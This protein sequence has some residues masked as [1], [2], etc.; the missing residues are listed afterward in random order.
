ML[1]VIFAAIDRRVAATLSL[2]PPRLDLHR[3]GRPGRVGPGRP[4]RPGRPQ[5]AAV[6]ARPPTLG[7]VIPRLLDIAQ[8]PAKLAE[9]IGGALVRDARLHR[10][11]GGVRPGVRRLAPDRRRRGGLPDRQRDRLGRCPTPGGIGAVEAALSAGLTAAGLHGA[12][13]FSAVLLFRTVTFW[14]P[15]PFGWA[16]AA[17][18]CSAARSCDLTLS[19]AWPPPA[20]PP[21]APRPRTMARRAPSSGASSAC[22]STRGHLPVGE[23]DAA[24]DPDRPAPEG[25]GRRA[26]PALRRRQGERRAR[27]EDRGQRRACRSAP[28]RRSAPGRRPRRRRSRGRCG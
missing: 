5:A 11:P 1:L 19:R 26:Q 21:A 17:T 16:R 9:G 28:R 8:Q 24:L 15:V 3:A 18:T 12:V 25:P 4:G 14:L 2:R 23:G 13:A 6:P 22:W 7:Q 27:R 20:T 10:L